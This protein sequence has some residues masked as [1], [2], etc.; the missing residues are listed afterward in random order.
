LLVKVAPESK[1]SEFRD[2]DEVLNASD[3]FKGREPLKKYSTLRVV[4]R[5]LETDFEVIR[6]EVQGVA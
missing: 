6:A 5:I 2:L 4:A 3:R 1:P